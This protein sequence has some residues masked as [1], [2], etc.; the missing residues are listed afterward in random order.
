MSAAEKQ[1]NQA[2]ERI[3]DLQKQLEVCCTCHSRCKLS[4]LESGDVELRF[5]WLL[6]SAFEIFRPRSAQSPTR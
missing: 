3:D 5:D 1:Y 2:N 6:C 4:L